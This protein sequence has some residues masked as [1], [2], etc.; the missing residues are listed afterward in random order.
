MKAAL[1]GALNLSILD[2]WW[3][4]WFDGENGWA[5][6]TAD[7]VED[8]ERRD[9]IEAAALYDLIEHQ[10]APRFYDRD[11]ERPAAELDR[12]DD[13]TPS[14]RSGPKVLASRMVRD[15]TEQLYGP[16]ARAGL[17]AER[18]A[19][20]AGARD[21]AAYKAKVRGAW[22]ERPRRPRRVLRRLGDCPQLGETLH[23]TSLRLARRPHPRRGRGAGRARPRQPPRRRAA[24]R[25]RRCRWPSW[26]PTSDGRHQFA[27]DL[28]A[29]LHRARS[30]TP[31]AS[32][33]ST[34]AGPPELA[35]PGRQRLT[36]RPL[37]SHAPAPPRLQLSRP[38]RE[39]SP[40]H[41]SVWCEG[42]GSGIGRES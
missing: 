32:C 5:I 25:L 24:R 9:D 39:P 40:S 6:P 42:E 11:D 23:V 4:E 19:S 18:G 13:C 37:P 15:Y 2:G 29:A 35:R 33:R 26:S 10:V 8:P 20:Y 3:D 27:G 28:V 16:A 14:P 21:L 7:G 38:E 41:H 22:R 30:A 31:C 34:P 36:P 1:N 17:G 12:D